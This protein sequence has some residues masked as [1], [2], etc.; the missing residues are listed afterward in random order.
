M[1]ET[2]ISIVTNGSLL[3]RHEDDLLELLSHFK[4]SE[5]AISIDCIGEQHNYWRSAKFGT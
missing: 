3:H 1:F 5:I 4:C 2:D